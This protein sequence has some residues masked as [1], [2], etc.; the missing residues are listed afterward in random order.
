[1]C[2]LAGVTFKHYAEMDPEVTSRTEV[3]R[4][5]VSDSHN[6]MFVTQPGPVAHAYCPSYL[7]G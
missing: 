4:C 3:G 7:K 1:M 6:P 5:P 2:L